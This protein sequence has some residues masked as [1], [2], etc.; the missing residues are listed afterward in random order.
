MNDQSSGTH[1][2]CVLL[3]VSAEE[4]QFLGACEKRA[5]GEWQGMRE[6]VLSI[7]RK[8]AQRLG[9]AAVSVGRL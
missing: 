3:V 8:A 6:D 5:E 1:Q 7:E 9:V 2:V 4:E